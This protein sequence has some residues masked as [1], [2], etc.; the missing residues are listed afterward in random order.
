MGDIQFAS[1]NEHVRLAYQTH[2]DP[3]GE[4]LLLIHGFTRQ[5][6]DW[7]PDWIAQFTQA[8]FYVI[9]FDN[10][11]I[12]ESTKMAHLGAPNRFMIMVRMMLNRPQRVPY[13]LHA[14]ARDSV[15]LLDVLNV[16]QAHVFGISMGATV[17]QLLAVAHP[18][19]VKTL[20]LM[21]ATT[22]RGDLPSA[23]PNL[24][25]QFVGLFDQSKQTKYVDLLV[26]MSPHVSS[27][28][29]PPTEETVRAAGDARWQRNQP[30]QKGVLRQAIAA[31]ATGDISEAIAA[32][33]APTLVL[34]GADDTLVPQAHGQ[35]V[36]EHIPNA[37][38]DVIE[39]MGHEPPPELYQPIAARIIAHM[40]AT[41]ASA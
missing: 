33:Q 28:R 41:Q 34:H 22:G 31:V 4:P 40:Q 13:T 14:M 12:G 15:G 17:A 29:Y 32:I 35:D 30:E 21:S 11:D 25:S 6:I 27:Q 9:T 10:R 39:D 37:Q 2:G 38:F 18:E 36:A 1:I 5:L 8:G 23:D 7:S 19:R 20:T 26:T 3:S 24:R 16:E